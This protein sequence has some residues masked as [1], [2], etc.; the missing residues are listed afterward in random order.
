[1]KWMRS[2]SVWTALGADGRTY[3]IR[4]FAWGASL[5]VVTPPSTTGR[6]IGG[7]DNVRAAQRRARAL[8]SGTYIADV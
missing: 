3:R 7:F 8:A 2:R 1:M 6:L 4:R 5:R